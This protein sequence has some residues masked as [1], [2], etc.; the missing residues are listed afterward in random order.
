MHALADLVL[1]SE[2]P[3]LVA[4]LFQAVRRVSHRCGAVGEGRIDEGRQRNIG[5]RKSVIKPEGWLDAIGQVRR[6]RVG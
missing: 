6:R 4:R 1:E 2:G 3:V 5:L